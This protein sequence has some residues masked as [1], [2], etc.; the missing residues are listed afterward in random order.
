[1]ISS[2]LDNAERLAT[3]DY[4]PTDDDIVRARLRTLDI[5]E[6]ELNVAGGTWSFSFRC[7]NGTGVF[8]DGESQMWK[9]YDVGGSRTQVLIYLF[10]SPFYATIIECLRFQQR[11]AWLP[12]FDQV[13]AIIFLAP[14]SCFDERL[15]EDPRVNRLEDSFI[16]WKAVCSSKLLS[17]TALII[18]LNKIDILENKIESGV[19]V[20]RHLPSYGD[21]P[22]DTQSVVK[23]T[24]A[25][26]TSGK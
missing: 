13:N 3:R 19:M 26:A 14:I 16:L 25:C 2:F 20:N 8:P 23:C 11:H 5:Q 15:E 10:L 12:Y 21:R 1:M 4:G 17:R 7:I 9:I 6:Y 22:N 24:W 18:F